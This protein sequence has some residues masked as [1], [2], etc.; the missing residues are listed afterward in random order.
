VTKVSTGVYG[1][2]V[3]VNTAG[4]WNYRAQGSGALVAAQDGRFLVNQSVIN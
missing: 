2:N 1:V 4:F 3:S